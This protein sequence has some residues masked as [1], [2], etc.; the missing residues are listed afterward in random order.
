MGKPMRESG[1][2]NDEFAHS[3]RRSRRELGERSTWRGR[4]GMVGR[5]SVR[6]C[7]PDRQPS[8]RGVARPDNPVRWVKAL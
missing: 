6:D 2:A 1:P 7:S 3:K 8:S 4:A 5:S